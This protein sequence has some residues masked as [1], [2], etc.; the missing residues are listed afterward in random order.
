RVFFSFICL[1]LVLTLTGIRSARAAVPYA[2]QWTWVD[3]SN[4]GGQAGVYGTE[5]TPDANNVPGIRY[6]AVSW[7]DASGNLWLFGGEGRDINYNFSYLNDLWKFDPVSGQWTWVDGASTSDQIG[8]YG[9]EDTPA[10]NN[11]PGARIASSS[12]IDGNGNLWLFG[13]NGYDSTGT[14]GRLN[15][16]WKFDPVSGQWTW[17]DGAT[18]ID[19]SGTYGTE[20]TPAVNNVPGARIASGSWVDGNGNL[21]LFGGYGK[22]SAGTVYYLNDLW[23]FDPIS[24]QWTWVDGSNVFGQAGVYGT[25]D[26]PAVN[27]VPGARRPSASWIDGSGNL[28]LFGGIGYPSTVAISDLNDLWK[29]D[30]VS[31]QWTWVD[32]ATTN[33]QSG[34]YGTEDTPD[35]NNVPGARDNSV[36]W[37]DATG[38]FW[39]FGGY[40]KDSAGT[41]GSLNDLWKF[42]PVS[43]QW[44][45][46]D[47]SN[48]V[49]QSGI[50][51]VEDTPNAGNVPGG[52]AQATAWID[53][54]ENLWLFGGNGR[55]SAGLLTYLDDLW[56]YSEVALMTVKSTGANDGWVLEATEVSN[57]GGIMNSTAT[58]FNLGDSAADQQYRTILSFDTS[59]LPDTAVISS[60]TLK[61]K[62][63]SLSGTDPFTILGSLKID[64]RKP[65][66]GNPILELLDFN[67][68]AGKKNMGAFNPVPV[69]S[70]YSANIKTPGK[71][72][73]NRTGTTQFRLTFTIDDNDN[74]VA[75]YIQ[76]FSG[77]APSASRPKLMIEYYIP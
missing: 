75:D 66:F 16:L 19:Q 50:Y 53:G 56:K 2:G 49:D 34:T 22:D 77:N 25:E 48:T 40:G 30:P 17:V 46:V 63:K 61:I 27:N 51:G 35:A 32:G 23:K 33:D 70:W 72:Y 36:G 59:A 31:G 57:T 18:T 29:F 21:W 9:T 14:K 3:G 55:N 47:G 13:G 69:G 5:D 20:D 52:R 64:L 4:V 28:W 58:S 7:T 45:W 12:W 71:N 11:V 8:T 65:A 60:A 38:N 44:T 41:A 76:F 37:L 62:K 43:G 26:T 68:T 67:A 73:I 24:G 1:S 10:V 39:L 6:G 74:S 54:N 42:D 15:D